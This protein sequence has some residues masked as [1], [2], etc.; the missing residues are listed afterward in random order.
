ML[1][2][3]SMQRR[4]RLVRPMQHDTIS[5]EDFV[6]SHWKE[7]E[8]A[9]F[10][11]VW[12]AEVANVPD[13]S[14]STFH[15]VTGLLL[16]IWRR[17]PESNARVYRLQTDDGERVIGRMLS[18]VEMEAVCRNLGIDAPKISNQDAWG[19]IIDGKVTAH[20]ADGLSL[21]CVRV[22]N[23]NRVEDR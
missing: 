13:F 16:P 19:M 2:D 22:M 21:R 5:V 9:E 15:L 3:G 12:R 18:Q 10:S 20:L 4:F 7:A 6:S 17:L 23:E 14:T 8:E 11:E 1:D